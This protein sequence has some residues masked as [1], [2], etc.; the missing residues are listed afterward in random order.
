MNALKA[1]SRLAVHPNTIHGRFQ[2]IQDLTNLNP[3]AYGTLSELLIV[4]ASATDPGPA[5]EPVPGEGRHSNQG[6]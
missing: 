4:I 5:A 1:A 3:R 2:K 6:F